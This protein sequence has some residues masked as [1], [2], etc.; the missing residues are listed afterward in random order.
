[1]YYK[2]TTNVVQIIV[3]NIPPFLP[4][5]ERRRDEPS[6]NP[7]KK[8]K[9]EMRSLERSGFYTGRI[10]RSFLRFTDEEILGSDR[11]KIMPTPIEHRDKLIET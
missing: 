9:K 1:M 6:R 2:C 10:D 5:V 4:D 8:R 3:K 7:R 11:K